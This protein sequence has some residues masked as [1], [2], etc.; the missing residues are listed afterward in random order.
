LAKQK[1]YRKNYFCR[2]NKFTQKIILVLKLRAK[3]FQ[4]NIFFRTKNPSDKIYFSPKPIF[5]E[6]KSF[7]SVKFIPSKNISCQK[8]ILSV[9]NLYFVARLKYFPKLLITE[10]FRLPD[11]N[12]D[13]RR[14]DKRR[15][16]APIDALRSEFKN[17]IFVIRT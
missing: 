13:C 14:R 16:A 10:L 3:F 4:P 6:Q 2:K 17:F 12:V 9:K 1:F 7:F 5:H 11:A 15:I 8:M